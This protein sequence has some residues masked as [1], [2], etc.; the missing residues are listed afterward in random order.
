MAGV[1]DPPLSMSHVH[2]SFTICLQPFPDNASLLPQTEWLFFSWKMKRI[3]LLCSANGIIPSR[4]IIIWVIS[5]HF[6]SQMSPLGFQLKPMFA[7]IK[8]GCVWDVPAPT[9]GPYLR[10]TTPRK[11]T[12][13]HQLVA[14]NQFQITTHFNKFFWRIQMLGT[15]R[16][17]P[18]KL[19][20]VSTA[21]SVFISHRDVFTNIYI[22]YKCPSTVITVI[23]LLCGL[24]CTF[25]FFVN[26]LC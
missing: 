7:G 13:T 25:E 20:N 16:L 15:K 8:W 11:T 23:S 1:E 21:D 12:S 14:T 19:C 24:P 3:D 9:N 2:H 10:G 22:W 18:L 6:S 26:R 5:C 4:A 17:K